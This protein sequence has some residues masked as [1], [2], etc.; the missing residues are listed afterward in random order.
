MTTRTVLSILFIIV[1]AC[2]S[3]AQVSENYSLSTDSTVNR[4]AGINRVYYATRIDKRP[5]IDGKLNDACW[6]TGVWAGGFTQQ[7]PYQGKTPSEDTEIKI[8]YDN[9]NLYVGFKCYDKMP[10][11]IRPILSRRDEMAGDI[12][13]I[14]LDSYHDKQTA[15]EFNVAASGQKVDLV[16]LGAYNWD[17]NWDAVWD[18]K[19]QVN[20]S[21]WT[22]EIQIPF[23]QI[24]FAPGK[25]QVW[26][27]HVWRWI[28]RLQE[29]SQWKLIP[30]DA[31]AMVY[32]FGELR[33]IEGVRPKTNYEF[34]PYM[35]ARFSPNT[36]Q[37]NKT[38]IGFGLD[39][40]IGLNS[41]LT[42]DYAINPDFGQVEA[43]PAVLNLTSYEVFNEEKRPFFLEGNTILDFSIG[44]D[45][46]F[47][48]RRIG[49]APSYSP[50]LDENQTISIAENTPILTALKLTGKTKKGLSVGVV[51]SFTSKE[52]A[53]IYR[54][55]S[56]SKKAVEPFTNYMVGRIK[57]DFDK[58][59]TV[60]GGMLTSTIR[61]IKDDQ[62]EF[63]P[64]S[65]VAGGVDFQ[66]NWKKR[67][68]FVD[69]KGFFSDIHGEKEAISTLQLSP[70]HYFQREDASY[71]EYDP[72]RT[73][74]SGWGGS[75]MGG[76]R[77]GKFRATGTLNWRS[78]GVDIN[79]V[80]YLYQADLIEQMVNLKYTVNQPKGIVRSYFIEFE[81]EHDWSFGGENTLDRLKLHGYLLLKNLW[82]VHLNLRKN[83]NIFDT[84]EL[85][86]G[87]RLYKD[88]YNDAELFIQSNAVK[89]FWVGFGPRVKFFSDKISKTNYFTAYLRWQLSD[90]F[91]ISSQTVFDHSIDHHQFVT[92]TN[93]VSGSAKYLVGTIDRNTISSTIRFEYFI[94][95]EISLQYYGNPYA[96]T[97]TYE[98]F[99]EV[100]DA[101]NKSLDKRYISLLSSADN[102]YELLRD[103]SPAYTI[104][105]PD[106]NFHEFK[107]N[108]VGRWEFR[109]GSTL[110]L[111]WT[112]TRSAYSDKLDQS[113]WNSFGDIMN[114][115]A[116]NVFMIKFSY[117]FSL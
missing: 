5:K 29:E 53:S 1:G 19:A 21:L 27:M 62:L 102:K 117:W 33:G 36:D 50:D 41:G 56:K 73:S 99:R 107:S 110:Y 74:L 65:A 68:Y 45:M 16:H 48:S 55:D 57:Q 30:I 13:G 98:G 63:L 51:Q 61:N 24:R 44:D 12:A 2:S 91:S 95:P 97:G 89:D 84:R 18:G 20:D 82:S 17:F 105:N 85:R 42:L 4:L 69:F 112:N 71:L 109:P 67:K 115:K 116:Q 14:A 92:R 103:G 76:K 104:H 88:G 34:L 66:H 31:P 75:L 46:L 93:D 15:Y 86:G 106:F 70:V 11:G 72:D 52:E 83:Y 78:P 87:P 64:N 7:T 49:H 80:G 32:L 3:F 9:N 54:G 43:D 114:V 35:N 23:S 59:N 77:S 101:S 96:S 111:V 81:Q 26:G 47:Y 8:L 25:E 6:D 100:A 28:D 90:R 22:S 37:E 38:N 108:L 113:I 39:G 60:L 79:D 94:S 58:G 40:K 10:G